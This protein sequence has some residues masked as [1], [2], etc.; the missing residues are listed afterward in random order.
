MVQ[1]TDYLYSGDTVLHIIRGYSNDL[2]KSASATHNP[3]DRAHANFLLQMEELLE[4]NNFLTSQSQRIREFYKYM[5]GHYGL[6]SF[7]FRGRIKSLIR[8]EE[9]YNGYIVSFI[10]SYHAKHG[11]YPS[12][13]QIKEELTRFK[14]LI[15]YRI[16]LSVPSCHLKIGQDRDKLEMETLYE[17]ANILP[18]FLEERGFSAQ[19]ASTELPES[20]PLLNENV[21]PY[22]KDYIANP[23]DGGYRSLHLTMYDNLSRGYTE[24]QLRTKAMDDLAEIGE[25]NH[26]VYE[27]QQ[28]RERA[29]RQQVPVGECPYFDDAY[30][31]VTNLQ[32]LDLSKID[33]NM[34]TALDKYRVNDGC[35][36]Y[37]GRLILP[38]EHLSRFQ[39]DEID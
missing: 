3:L 39:N 9:K 25:A 38:Y 10:S 20:S 6:F 18:E 33:V 23:K 32:N 31:R 21:R 22:Y 4:H 36:L 30:E 29:R 34:F 26:S 13:A 24:I 17:I 27:N 28:E 37:Y 7:T 16:V 15:A 35:G 1:L 2:R 14:D 19:L 8:S 11:T 5:A 12:V